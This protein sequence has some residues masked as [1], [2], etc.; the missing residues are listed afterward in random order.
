M[1]LPR[2]VLFDADGVVQLPASTWR[3]ALKALCPEPNRCNE[4]LADI[5]AA[6][7]PCLT[8]SLDFEIS[9]S[10]VLGRWGA[11]ASPADAISIWT[12]IE[13][14]E[15]ILGIVASVKSAGVPVALATNQQAY[16]AEF[17]AKQLKYASLFDHL[18]FSCELGYSKPNAD[19]FSTALALVGFEP[20][21]ALF[22]DDHEANVVAAR[23]CGLN[24]EVFHASEGEGRLREL[25]LEYG[26]RVA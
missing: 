4:F 7:A 26:L 15:D 3:P 1:A 8:G 20:S 12:Q 25:L 11:D 17:M 9:L 19:Y 18:F 6:E 5:F 24:G 21:E 16:R 22:I 2:I 10:E 14:R 13:P 23:S